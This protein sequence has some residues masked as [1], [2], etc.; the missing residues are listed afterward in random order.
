[1]IPSSSHLRRALFCAV[2]VATAAAFAAPPA[3][4]RQPATVVATSGSDATFSVAATATDTLTYQWRHLGTPITNGTDASLTL[5][6]LTMADAGFYDVVVTA[7]GESTTSQAGRLIT[8]PTHYADQFCLD[9]SF[10]PLI[11]TTG[12]SAETVAADPITGGFY[13]GGEFST[14]D[15][16]RRWNLARFDAAGVIDPGFTP[17]VDGR[18]LTIAVQPDGNVLIGGAFRFVNNVQRGGIARL[19][20]DG[21]LDRTFGNNRGFAGPVT[22]VGIQSTGRIV[23]C[24]PG[25]YDN[26]TSLQYATFIRLLPNGAWDPSFTPF[27]SPSNSR[28]AV[29]R[30]DRVVFQPYHWDGSFVRILTNGAKD[31]SFTAPSDLGTILAYAVQSNGCPVLTTGTTAIRLRSDGSRDDSYSVRIAMFLAPTDTPQITIDSQDRAIAC[32]GGQLTRIRPDG[33][34]DSSLNAAVFNASA[35]ATLAGDRISMVGS[36]AG[37]LWVFGSDGTLVRT[38]N[39]EFYKASNEITAAIPANGEAWLVGGAFCRF[40]G[41]PRAGI[42][43]ILAT[44]AVDPTFAPPADRGAVSALA[45]QAD[46]RLLAGC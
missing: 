37:G 11:E 16:V 1:M 7:G 44:G 23:V 14:I 5:D 12:A 33:T 30:Q 10:L 28:F 21:S 6:D 18:V 27:T 3:I 24:G 42:A 26:L 34:K 8:T 20:T 29:D 13:V 46:G 17:Q 38:A 31:T 15:G 19:N 43:R 35:I 2:F 41:L 40:G 22:C 9:D 4:T 36:S 39:N 25:S 32:A 45:L